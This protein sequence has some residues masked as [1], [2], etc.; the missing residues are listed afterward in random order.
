MVQRENKK[1]C[2]NNVKSIGK[3]ERQNKIMN[4]SISTG[5][6]IFYKVSIDVLYLTYFNAF[7]NVIRTL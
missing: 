4:F 6:A 1:N 2:E 7:E 5:H 3:K